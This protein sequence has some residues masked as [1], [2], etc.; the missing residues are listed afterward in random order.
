MASD[1]RTD[2][3]SYCTVTVDD[4]GPGIP[5][6]IKEIVFN[7]MQRGDTKAKGSGMGLFLVKSLVE[8]YGGKVWAEDRIKGDHT[9]GAR[10]KVLLPIL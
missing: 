3:Q 2:G 1:M 6:H 8:D 9:R 10:F 4:N 5:D 7:R